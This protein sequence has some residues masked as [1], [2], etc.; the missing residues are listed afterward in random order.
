LDSSFALVS[1]GFAELFRSSDDRLTLEQHSPVLHSVSA[2]SALGLPLEAD[3]CEQHPAVSI[4]R[5]IQQKAIRL[6]GNL[7]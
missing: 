3:S 2:D 1:S 7:R 5:T 6:M 4:A